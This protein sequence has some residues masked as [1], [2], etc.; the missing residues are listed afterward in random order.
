MVGLA[1]LARGEISRDEF[2]GRYGHRGPH[3]FEV[4]IPRPGEDPA[5]IDAQLAGL[6]AVVGTGKATMRLHDGD[7]IRVDGERGTVERL[8]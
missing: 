3:E 6:P 7:R 4:S 1:R 2:A 5:W 8:G